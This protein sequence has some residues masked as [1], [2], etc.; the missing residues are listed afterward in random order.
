LF[1]AAASAIHWFEED[2][3]HFGTAVVLRDDEVIDI[4]IV[5]DERKFRVRVGRIRQWLR[6][7]AG[8]P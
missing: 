6:E 5:G 4:I 1:E 2:C 3:K 7:K 8:S